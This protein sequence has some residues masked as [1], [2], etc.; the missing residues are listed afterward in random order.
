LS[1]TLTD[2]AARLLPSVSQLRAVS[3]AVA[4][5]MALRAQADGVTDSCD[6]SVLHNRIRECI[7]DPRYHPYRK[8]TNKGF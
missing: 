3:V 2:K 1:P 5:A 4:K 6:E 8:L 7:W